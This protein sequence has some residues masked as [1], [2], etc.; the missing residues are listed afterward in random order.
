MSE[1]REFT[2]EEV[3][4]QFL[5]QVWS[6]IKYWGELIN[7]QIANG[8]A[9]ERTTMDRLQGLAFSILVTLDGGSIPLPSFV[10]APSPH[11]SDKQYNIDNGSNYFP[12]NHESNVSADISGCLHELF[13]GVGREMGMIKDE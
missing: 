12:E 13:H 7:E 2:T 6:N 10:V 4:R 1:S 9:T 11:P 5:E 8:T 3:R